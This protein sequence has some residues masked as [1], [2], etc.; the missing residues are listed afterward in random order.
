MHYTLK[1]SVF[2]PDD[3]RILYLNKYEELFGMI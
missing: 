1:N 2:K 3:E